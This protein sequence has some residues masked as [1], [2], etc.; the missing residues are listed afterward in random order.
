MLPPRLRVI[1]QPRRI[2]IGGGCKP[3][4][5]PGGA[6]ES[7]SQ[8]VN[9][10]VFDSGQGATAIAAAQCGGSVAVWA[11][12]PARWAR[13]E[14]PRASSRRRPEGA[15]HRDRLRSVLGSARV[16][17]GVGSAAREVRWAAVRLRR[18]ADG[19]QRAAR[20]AAYRVQ[21]PPHG[22][23]RT[24]KSAS[25]RRRSTRWS[26]SRRSSRPWSPSRTSSAP[27]PRPRCCRSFS[28]TCSGGS[29]RRSTSASVRTPESPPRSWACRMSRASRP[30][31]WVSTAGRSAAWTCSRSVRTARTSERA[32]HRDRDARRS[33]RRARR[34]GR[35]PTPARC[36]CTG[37]I[38]WSPCAGRNRGS[39]STRASGSRRTCRSYAR[40]AAG[41][42]SAEPAGG[43]PNRR[44]HPGRVA[45][46]ARERRA[47]RGLS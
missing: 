6:P 18:R 32:C 23:R 42:G 26:L 27:T 35:R 34:K 10:S 47:P 36:T 28:M 15:R 12:G 4:P 40:S 21:P 37:L 3:C 7:G 41:P 45:D 24:T 19:Q 20:P 11:A 1:P 2:L 14:Q 29:P 9:T 16:S 38:R 25:R 30:S 13:P 44:R 43:R 17:P 5:A 39:S 31:R 33:C 8:R 22:Q 46:G